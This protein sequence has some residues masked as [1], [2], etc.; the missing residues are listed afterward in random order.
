MPGEFS[1]END[2]FSNEKPTKN[3]G[4]PWENDEIWEPSGEI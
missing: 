2:A 4:R 1:K 3:M